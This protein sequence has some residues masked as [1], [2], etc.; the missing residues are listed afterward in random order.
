MACAKSHKA[1]KWTIR[2]IVCFLALFVLPHSAFAD[3]GEWGY[4]PVYSIE[5]LQDGASCLIGAIGEDGRV[6]L[7]TSA[8][9]NKTQLWAATSAQNA[10]GGVEHPSANCVWQ[11]QSNDDGTYN[12]LTAEGKYLNATDGVALSLDAKRKSRW[13]ITPSDWGFVVSATETPDRSLGLYAWTE[14]LFFANYKNSTNTTPTLQIFVPQASAPGTEMVLPVQG[15]QVVLTVGEKAVKISQQG[16]ALISA[17]GCRLTDGTMA[18]PQGASVF[19]CEYVADSVFVLRNERG[20][21]QHSLT[22]ADVPAHW[23]LGAAGCVACDASGKTEAEPYLVYHKETGAFCLISAKEVGSASY[24]PV[25]LSVCAPEATEETSEEGV[26]TL[27]G[28]WSTEALAS[29]NWQGISALDIRELVL[30][31]TTVDF[32]HRPAVCNVPILVNANAPQRLVEA[33]PFVLQCEGESARLASAFT[34]A[35]G[36][37]LKWKG[38]F[39]AAPG[40]LTYTRQMHAD[41]AWETLVVPFD[42]RVP[43]E[44]EARVPGEISANE[45]IFTKTDRLQANQAAIIRHKGAAGGEGPQLTLCNDSENVGVAVSECFLQGVYDTLRV[46]DS[47]AG[48]YLL[49]ASGRYFV[50]AA[51]GSW[52]ASFRAALCPEEMVEAAAIYSVRCSDDET[53]GCSTA[54]ADESTWQGACYDLQGRCLLQHTDAASFAMLPA[55]VYIVNGKIIIKQ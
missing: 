41:G 14:G 19:V 44:F 26:K 28:G 8:Q 32:H 53:A 16:S 15:S 9:R 31:Q 25:L 45:I 48:I 27:R 38:R 49:E 35:D 40:D 6:A 2:A 21:L 17:A 3:D 43:D 13:N 50:K 18:I 36:V 51:A 20:Y 39:S 37:P 22:C 29:V 12:I 23:T 54:V 10:H 4:Y 5:N 52:L 34:L 1:R 55:G 7:M 30:P 46:E 24:M 42:T 33:W 47:G 11:L